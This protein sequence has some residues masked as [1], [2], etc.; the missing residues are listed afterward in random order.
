MPRI[1]IRNISDRAYAWVF[2]IT[3][4]LDASQEAVLLQTVDS[5]LAG[6]AAHGQPITS[7]RE[8]REGSF[9]VVAAENDTDRTGC[10]IDRLFGTLRRLES[11]LGI[12]IVEA[13]RVFYRTPDGNVAAAS[14]EEFRERG[15]ATTTVFDTTAESL[16]QI[17]SGSWERAA[18]D[19]W[20]RALL[21]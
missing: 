8:V 10:S 14:R 16:G 5:F 4:R 21:T 11:E 15:D 7:A 19:S 17:R 3:P 1:D 12:S 13:S 20:H 6:W 18:R 9:L 2:G